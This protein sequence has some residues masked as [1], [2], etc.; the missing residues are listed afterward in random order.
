MSRRSS[1]PGVIASIDRIVAYRYGAAVDQVEAVRARQRTAGSGEEPAVAAVV[2]EIVRRYSRELA[3]VAALA[4]G[5]AALPGTG[6]AAAVMATG[7][8][9]AYTIG[10]LGEM[11][12]AIGIAH[13]HD[14]VSIEERR[15]WVLAVLSMGKGAVSGVEGIAGRVGAEGGARI[16]SSIGATQLDQ[17]N[18]KL[19]ARLVARLAT[20][21]S[22]ARLGR[23]LPFGIGAGVG[24]AGNVLIVRS[25]ARS[26]DRFFLDP[27]APPAP[28]PTRRRS[29]IDVDPDVI[30]VDVID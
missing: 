27:T 26:A 3:A 1:S 7:A 9:M 5:A 4:G 24:A 20:E 13:G 23:L 14:A 19:G 18:S 25:V 16:V 21:Q 28:P 10:K 2:D 15:A 22:A 11:V 30:D 17:V 12:L 8:D 29:G 6:T